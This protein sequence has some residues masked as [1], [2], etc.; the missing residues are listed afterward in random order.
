MIE[1]MNNKVQ[2]ILIVL[3]FL[4]LILASAGGGALLTGNPSVTTFGMIGTVT[5]GVILAGDI[6]LLFYARSIVKARAAARSSP[7]AI[8]SRMRRNTGRTGRIPLLDCPVPPRGYWVIDK[9]SRKT[10]IPLWIRTIR[11]FTASS[12]SLSFSCCSS[13]SSCSSF[14]AD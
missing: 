14:S 11:L 10:T 9:S 1:A 12:P 2:V 3:M 6:M 4:G 7:A 5:G 8:P 13:A